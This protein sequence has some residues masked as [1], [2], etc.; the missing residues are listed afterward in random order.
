M[1]EFLWLDA[2]YEAD[3]SVPCET[4]YDKSQWYIKQTDKFSFGAKGGHNGE[5]HNHCDIGSFMLVVDDEIPLDDFGQGLYGKFTLEELYSRIPEGSR[6]HSVPI[7]NGKQQGYGG[8]YKYRAENMKLEGNEL[9]LDIEKAYEEGL[10]DKIHRA[11]KIGEDN[12]ILT[13]DI[14]YSEQTETIVERFV[15]HIEPQ[16][17][18]NF[19]DYGKARIVFDNK[20]YKVSVEKESYRNH[21]NTKDLDAYL[22]D[23]VAADDR[24]THFEFEIEIK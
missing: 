13:D 12:I 11:F 19:V 3:E 24:E 14:V 2:D 8:D 18:E 22:V 23:F 5:P 9:S 21:Y 1:T 16:V 17:G 7:I 4:F 15:S 10:V 20:K 6:G